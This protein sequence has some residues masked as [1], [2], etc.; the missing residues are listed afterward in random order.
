MHR[1]ARAGT[2]P[3]IC[4]AAERPSR[5]KPGCEGGKRRRGRR[6]KGGSSAITATYVFARP[7]R[8]TRV[9]CGARNVRAVIVRPAS[10]VHP[11]ARVAP[12]AG[13]AGG[14]RAVRKAPSPVTP[15]P[16]HRGL[17]PKESGGALA[18]A[19][20]RESRIASARAGRQG[21]PLRSDRS[22][23]SR[24]APFGRVLDC[25]PRRG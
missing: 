20:G 7:A 13:D 12:G 16:P 15:T 24:G 1:S 22:T 21:S 6:G 4:D 8:E 11:R 10:P 2:R 9:W 23:A 3:L 18:R 19:I 14:R 5:R 17:A 25:R